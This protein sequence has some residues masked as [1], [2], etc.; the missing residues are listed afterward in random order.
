MQ[1]LRF[2]VGLSALCLLVSACGETP[3]PAEPTPLPT[4]TPI[5]SPTPL[6][7]PVPSPTPE[8]EPT[9]TSA[10]DD[11]PPTAEEYYLAAVA[12]ADSGDDDFAINLFTK[13]IELDLSF[14]DA[15]ND[16]GASYLALEEFPEAEA[17]FS[18]AIGLVP[19][20]ADY[21][22][23]RGVARMSLIEIETAIDDFTTAIDL[24]PAMV[25]AYLNRSMVYVRLQRFEE[26]LS[27][28]E[29]ILNLDPKYAEVHN[30]R[31]SIFMA[32]DQP[33][34]ALGRARPPLLPLY[35][36]T[37]TRT[38]TAPS[39]F[40]LSGRMSARKSMRISQLNWVLTRIGFNVRSTA[41]G[42][43]ATLPTSSSVL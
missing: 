12:Y 42:R 26:S 15:Y 4:L 19:D 32:L 38:L 35:S 41:F 1:T 8:P 34:E 3:P 6:P 27:D 13:A 16:R 33:R 39:S 9:S 18:K 7:T 2:F 37:A 5:P 23:N 30:Y 22:N 36:V 29:Q 40:S 17:D 20:D 31:G 11:A 24:D 25:D 10:A 21:Y 28:L 43:S 14:S